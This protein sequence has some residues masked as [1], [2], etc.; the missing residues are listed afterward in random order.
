[1]RVLIIHIAKSCDAATIAL[2]DTERNCDRILRIVAMADL[3][4]H[5]Y[6]SNSLY[7]E[8]LCDR[9]QLMLP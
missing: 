4:C 7:C 6:A 1:L 9:I 5:S 2:I 3:W 8:K